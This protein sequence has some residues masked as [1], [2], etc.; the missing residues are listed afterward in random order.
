MRVEFYWKIGGYT[1]DKNYYQDEE[2]E[3]FETLE[4]LEHE[5][6]NMK[7]MMKMGKPSGM[8]RT[9]GLFKKVIGD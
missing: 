4:D 5:L 7:K 6:K 2:F 3:E 9:A 1:V 8:K